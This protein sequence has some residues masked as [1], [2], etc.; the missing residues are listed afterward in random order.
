MADTSLKQQKW[1]GDRSLKK[2]L[3]IFGY[4]KADSMVP[5]FLVVKAC[6]RTFGVSFRFNGRELTKIGCE[7]GIHF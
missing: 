7:G 5:G 4:L 6:L 1:S 3:S 2:L